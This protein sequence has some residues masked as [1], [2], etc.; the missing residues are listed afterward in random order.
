MLRAGWL[1]GKVEPLTRDEP[2]HAA[3]DTEAANPVLGV[4]QLALPGLTPH[5]PCADA[6]RHWDAVVQVRLLLVAVPAREPQIVRPI[7]EVKQIDRPVR[8]GTNV[9]RYL[10]RCGAATYPTLAA[11]TN[12]EPAT[13]RRT[14]RQAWLPIDHRQPIASRCKLSEEIVEN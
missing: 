7:G 2:A 13:Q 9:I 4:V 14:D 11:V 8:A 5:A 10:L 12:P 1:A 6:E 3:A